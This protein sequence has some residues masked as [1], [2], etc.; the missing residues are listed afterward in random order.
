MARRA[1]FRIGGQEG[2]QPSPSDSRSKGVAR[3][4]GKASVAQTRFR[5]RQPFKTNVKGRELRK[6]FVSPTSVA[7]ANRRKTNPHDPKSKDPFMRA[8]IGLGK[9][10]T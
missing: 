6:T 7:G 9:N 8:G 1:R 10:D 3:S 2:E 4:G 5:T